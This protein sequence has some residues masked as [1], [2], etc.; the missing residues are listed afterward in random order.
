MGD[1]KTLAKY[2]KMAGYNQIELANDLGI[3][4]GTLS[5]WEN[6]NDLIPLIYF[7]EMLR[8][9]EIEDINSIDYIFTK[10]D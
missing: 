5:K 7:L 1:K 8:I 10:K 6:R 4:Q 9:L 2:R 3:N